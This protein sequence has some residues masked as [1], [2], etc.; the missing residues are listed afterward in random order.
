MNTRASPF[1]RYLFF[2]YLFLVVYASLHP[3]TDWRDIGISPFNFIDARLPRYITIFD[4]IANVL[5]YVPLAALAVLAAHPQLRGIRAW[6]AAALGGCLL[7]L[8][9]EALQTYLPA[10]IPSNLDWALNSLG[11]LIGA[12]IGAALVRAVVIGGLLYKLRAHVF[13][14]GKRI[15]LGLILLGAWLLSQLNPETLLFGTGDLRALF[16]SAPGILYPAAMF[17]RVEAI[18]TAGNAIAVALL[19]SLLIVHGG[20]RRSLFLLLLAAACAVRSVAFSVLFPS[21]NALAWLTPGAQIGLLVGTALALIALS[22]PR[23]VALG[24]CALLL[25]L[26]AALVNLAPDNPYFLHSLQAWPQGH[27]LNFNGLTRVV[28]ILWPFVAVGYLLSMQAGQHD[29]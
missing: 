8:C 5:A 9:M 29:D 26:S 11:A 7:S 4:V 19:C 13:R 6:L 1:I 2:G 25:M 14:S 15:D 27:F 21:Q 16:Q 12:S 3:L 18:I 28:S 24:I 17:V 22:L 23:Q 10:R 20:P